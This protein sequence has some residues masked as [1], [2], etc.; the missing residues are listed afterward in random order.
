MAM[1]KTLLISIGSLAMVAAVVGSAAAAP[2]PRVTQ[3]SFGRMPDGTNVT[4]YTLTN[5]SGAE[6]Q[7]TNYGGAVVSLKV[8]DRKGKLDDVVLG[9]D[10]LS[11][12][13]QG[14][15]PYFGALIGRYG[16]RIANG[17]FSLEGVPYTLAANNG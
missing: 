13:L 1:M 14:G 9:F 3:K 6:V 12:Y 10:T 8:P 17:K 11:G 4:L 5:A 2:T 16:N 15:N 7:I